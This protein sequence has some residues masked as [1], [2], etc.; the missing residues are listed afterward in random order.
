MWT[1]IVFSV[2]A[3]ESPQTNGLLWGDNL[4]Y[5]YDL[6]DFGNINK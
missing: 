4:Y 5:N 3:F 2:L 1:L 6:Y